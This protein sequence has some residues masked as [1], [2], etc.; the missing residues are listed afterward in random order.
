MVVFEV[1]AVVAVVFGFG[2]GCAVAATVAVYR[3]LCVVFSFAVAETVF[4]QINTTKSL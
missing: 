3:V 1:V 2:V 4:L